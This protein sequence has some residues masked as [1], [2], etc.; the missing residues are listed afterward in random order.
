MGVSDEPPLLDR[1]HSWAKAHA[2]NRNAT[3]D[4]PRSVLPVTNDIPSH[5]CNRPGSNNSTGNNVE[6]N[7]STAPPPPAP[8]PTHT[9][10]D[11]TPSSSLGQNEPGSPSGIKGRLLRFGLHTKDALLYSPINVLLI[12][13][14]IGIAANFAHL[15]AEIIF[16]MNAVAIIPLAG[17]LGHATESVASRLGDTI[18]ALL[19]VTFGNAVELII[20]IALVKNEIRIVQASLIG[21]I[22]ANLLLILGMAF[23]FGGLRFQEQVYNNTIT[24]MSA[25]LLSLSVMSLLLPTAFYASF[26]DNVKGDR[27]TLKI[28]RGTSVVLLLVYVLYLLFQLKSHAYLYESTPQHIIDEESHPG[29]LTEMLAS[30]SSSS[31]SDDSSSGGTDTSSGSH[32]TAKRIKRAFRHR[33]RRKSSASSKDA[34]SIPSAVSSP[35]G[36]GHCSFI[37]NANPAANHN[38][39]HHDTRSRHGSVLGA[40]MSGDEADT[41]GERERRDCQPRIRDFEQGTIRSANSPERKDKKKKKKHSKRSKREGRREVFSEKES[42]NPAEKVTVQ[43]DDTGPRLGFVDEITIAPE[44]NNE[45]KRPFALRQFS[46]RPRRPALPGLLSNTV[47]STQQQPTGAATPGLRRTSSLPDRLNRTQSTQ[48]TISRPAIY[49]FPQS[50][51]PSERAHD[52]ENAEDAPNMSRT[53]AIVLLLV[54]TGLVAL[55]AEFLVNSIPPMINDSSVSQAFIG[56]IILPIVG[57]AAEH[58]TAVTVATK[59]KM[60]LAIGVAV[61]S[62]IQIALFITPLLVIIGWCLNKD[63]S[64][65]FNLFETISLFVTAFVVNFLVLDGRSNYLEGSLLIAAYVIIAVAAFF[66]P[67]VAEQSALGGNGSTQF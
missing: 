22:L 21:S 28:S 43:E 31:S 57:N 50:N 12:F 65:Y 66:Y 15:N 48:N 45:G 36:E 49:P 58:V 52:I 11:G 25:C 35:S 30:S 38:S 59:N 24:Q 10:T 42:A 51:A 9:Q 20:F 13:V 64:L 4:A 60:D 29:I 39:S 37:E 16:A 33:K 8:P 3:G 61:G 55:C 63:M 7:T 46:S 23:L 18:G 32:T 19:N 62:S 54:T 2:S 40:I 53:A 17:L 34:P 56:L 67:E 47:F 14:P 1:I 26:S 41:D 27:S 6:D 5:E 44:T